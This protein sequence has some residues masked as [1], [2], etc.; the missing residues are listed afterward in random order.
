MVYLN[1]W[2]WASSLIKKLI[3]RSLLNIILLCPIFRPSSA[4]H[5]LG[6][7]EE[8][9]ETSLNT[10]SVMTSWRQIWRF[11]F[12]DVTV[13]CKV[14]A[15]R[16]LFVCSALAFSLWWTETHW[17]FSWNHFDIFCL[18]FWRSSL[19]LFGASS[20]L[21]ESIRVMRYLCCCAAWFVW[22]CGIWFVPCS[23]RRISCFHTLYGT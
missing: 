18:G 16:L 11:N 21:N 9:V 12:D 7:D 2:V 4:S 3:T 20:L 1:S 22:W 23:R 15:W 14:L 10:N 19:I 6:S 17:F 5:R 8:T 13:N